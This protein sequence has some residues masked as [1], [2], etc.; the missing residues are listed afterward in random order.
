M[1]TAPLSLK[2]LR[3][4]A[5]LGNEQWLDAA[6][7]IIKM[8]ARSRPTLTSDDA[9]A[10]LQEQKPDDDA[11]FV[12]DGRTMGAAFAIAAQRG[13]VHA[14]DRTVPSVRKVCHRR[15]VR[16]WKSAFHRKAAAP[17]KGTKP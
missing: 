17:R 9:W 3:S 2:A 5:R 15:P 6:V 4:R 14:T 8:L 12:F 16:I 7:E 1:T 10:M 11:A 13:Y